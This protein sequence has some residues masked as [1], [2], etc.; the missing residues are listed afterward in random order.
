MK[1]V[2]EL[3]KNE[4]LRK[5]QKKKKEE[6]KFEADLFNGSPL[7]DIVSLLLLCHILL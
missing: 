7:L 6:K 1:K 5:I 2:A 4:S 3:E